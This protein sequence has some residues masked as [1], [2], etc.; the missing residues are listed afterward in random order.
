MLCEYPY[1][2]LFYFLIAKKAKG[3][4]WGLFL[5]SL[6]SFILKKFKFLRFFLMPTVPISRVLYFTAI[7]IFFE[8]LKVL[9]REPITEAIMKIL[10]FLCLLL[11]FYK[12][13][14]IMALFIFAYEILECASWIFTYSG[15]NVQV[16][17]AIDL[18]WCFE[19]HFSLFFAFSSLVIILV[20]VTHYPLCDSKFIQINWHRYSIFII[21]TLLYLFGFVTTFKNYLYPYEQMETLSP[22]VQKLFFNNLKHFLFDKIEVKKYQNEERKNLIILEIE[23]L[24]QQILGS[25]NKM[26]P[27][28]MPFLSNLSK[29]GTFVERVETQ[30]YTTWSV[31]SLFAAQCNMPLLMSGKL[32]F[33]A[34][35][36]HLLKQ[37]RCIGDYL[38][39]QGYKLF[40][41]LCNVFIANFKKHLKM[42]HWVVE[43][44]KE[45]KFNLD[46]DLFQYIGDTIIPNLTKKENQPFVLHIANADTHP[47]P[48]YIV[49]ER[50]VKHVP[51]KFNKMLKSFNCFDY[52]IGQFLKK[53]EASGILNNTEVIIYGDHVLMSKEWKSANIVDPRY[54]VF[55]LPY[56]NEMKRNVIT[57]KSS[58]YDMAP[59]IMNLLGISE[60][61]PHFPFGESIFS[62]KIGIM[63]D[64][65]HFRFIYDFQ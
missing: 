32:M 2:R 50:C 45:H 52:I 9:N 28:S 6:F 30:P 36:F 44:L 56:H 15:F 20:I 49:D 8:V 55:M 10:F 48:N 23:S 3:F 35:S 43:D 22:A 18:N 21:M 13:V 53:V 58:L 54:I 26:F 62:S 16:L 29:Y 33:N 38:S 1:L 5:F 40:S 14:N 61:S 7:I 51:K 41:F 11:T 39:S 42:H 59:T 60:Y 24:E 27:N 64:N 63:P 65:R 46:Y 17:L 19:H 57:K 47:F 37:H 34:A 25:F 31:A 4:H 12:I